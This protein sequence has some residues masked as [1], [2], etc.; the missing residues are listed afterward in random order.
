MYDDSVRLVEM[1]EHNVISVFLFNENEG[2]FQ[3]GE[4]INKRFEAA[5]MNGYNWDALIRFYVN[6]VDTDLM[7]A[8]E[9]DPESGMF[10]ARM[11]YSPQ[12]LDRMRR[13]ESHIRTL[14]SDEDALFRFIEDN[15][16]AIEWD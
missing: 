5:Y 12:N 10:S 7:N 15:L 9:T 3:L 2:I 13:F 11:S 16:G 6:T 4:R 1:P 8:I 14:V